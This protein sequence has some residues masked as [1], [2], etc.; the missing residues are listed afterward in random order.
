MGPELLPIEKIPLFIWGGIVLIIGVFLL[1]NEDIDL[2]KNIILIIIGFA[3]II[4]DIKK[5]LAKLN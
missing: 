2:W 5:R 4:Y 3:V 1:W